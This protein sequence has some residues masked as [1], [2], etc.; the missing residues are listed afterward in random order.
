MKACG[1]ATPACHS[2]EPHSLA[3][4]SK[5][6]ATSWDWGRQKGARQA[7]GVRHRVMNE[8]EKG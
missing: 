4:G 2:G 8:R 1:E 3:M 5:M 7:V 6:S